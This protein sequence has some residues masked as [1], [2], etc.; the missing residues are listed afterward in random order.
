MDLIAKL[1]SGDGIDLVS[2]ADELF[3]GVPANG[4]PFGQESTRDQVR[5]L[6]DRPLPSGVRVGKID[7][8]PEGF[9]GAKLANSLPLS[10]V[11][12]RKP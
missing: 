1:L 12:L 11:M 8:S 2:I 6:I 5:S 9:K 7:H 3:I 4:V 10:M